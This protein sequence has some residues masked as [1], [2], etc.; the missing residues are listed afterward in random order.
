MEEIVLTDG[1]FL[2]L[3]TLI[4]WWILAFSLCE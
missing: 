4:R 1:L 2:N 3:G